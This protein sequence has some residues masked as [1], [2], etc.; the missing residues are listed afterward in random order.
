[1]TAEIAHE[2][3]ENVGTCMPSKGKRVELCSKCRAA[4][5]LDIIF[6]HPPTG[7]AGRAFSIRTHNQNVVPPERLAVIYD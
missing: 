2:T 7:Q 4:L 5:D 1:M 3:R 6:A